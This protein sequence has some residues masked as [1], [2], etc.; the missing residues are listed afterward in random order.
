MAER[1]IPTLG[2]TCITIAPGAEHRPPRLGQNQT[3]IQAISRAGGAPLLI[4]HL[5]DQAS[6]R[7][8]YER[9]DGLLLPGGEDI[10]PAHY[11]QVA[12]EA[13]GTPSP[14]RDETEL[15]L[16]RWAAAE[17]K[18][19]LA[20]CRGIQVLNVALGGSLY[21]DIASQLPG[22]GRHD[23]YPDLPRDLRPHRVTIEP[24]TRLASLL[25]RG[26]Q[27]V[28]SLHHQAAENVAPGLEV[29]ARAEDGIVEALEVEGH[30]FA[31]GVQWHPEE[32]ASEDARQQGLFDAL[33]EASRP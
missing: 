7:R 12:L 13:C 10:D 5:V 6:L 15:R 14:E 28:N 3:Y 16:A 8:V 21:Q 23:W 17:G 4:P 1:Q 9:L 32:L 31:L 20:I 25:G 2:I 11:N 22:A 26:E 29:A 27:G 33:V 19:L 24:G 30:P 18:P